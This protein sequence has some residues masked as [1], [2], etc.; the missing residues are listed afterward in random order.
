MYQNAANKICNIACDCKKL[1]TERNMIYMKNLFRDFQGH[2]R[3]SDS[4]S[5]QLPTTCNN[6]RLLSIFSRYKSWIDIYYEWDIIIQDWRQTRHGFIPINRNLQLDA[7]LFADDLVLIASTEDDLQYS[8]HNLN[9]DL[10]NRKTNVRNVINL[11]DKF[12]ATE[13]TERK[14]SEV[15]LQYRIAMYYKIHSQYLKRKSFSVI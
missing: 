4:V 2:V 10:P 13:C 3:F 15:Q 14:K 12:R 6:I 11:V 5:V 9:K 1:Q 8:V 7:L